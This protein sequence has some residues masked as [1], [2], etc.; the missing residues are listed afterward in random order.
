MYFVAAVEGVELVRLGLRE[1][2]GPRLLQP[3]GQF[4]PTVFELT[5]Q[6]G[7]YCG[8]WRL[9]QLQSEQ[10][11]LEGEVL[12]GVGEVLPRDAVALPVHA[13]EVQLVQGARTLHIGKGRIFGFWLVNC[14]NEPLSGIFA[15]LLQF[16]VFTPMEVNCNEE[17]ETCTINIKNFDQ[18]KLKEAL[19]KIP[20][21]C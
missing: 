3:L 1:A 9:V 5:L 16:N 12:R 21:Q 17:E 4:R 15:L 2:A 20:T 13:H 8:G 10:A 19:E 14:L 7:Y 11:G 6:V 18:I